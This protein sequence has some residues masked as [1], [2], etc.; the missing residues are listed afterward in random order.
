[1]MQ[2]DEALAAAFRAARAPKLEA[3]SRK[4][5]LLLLK[6]RSFDFLES[7]ILY[8]RDANLFL[9]AL[10]AVLHFAV[11]SAN[12]HFRSTGG[13]APTATTAL[14]KSD[15]VSAPRIYS[16]L[17][18]LKNRPVEMNEAL[19]A[20][21]A[22]AGGDKVL[23]AFLRAMFNTCKNCASDKHLIDCLVLVCEFLE[24]KKTSTS[25]SAIVEATLKDILSEFLTR[26][27]PSRTHRLI[28]LRLLS[29]SPSYAKVAQEVLLDRMDDVLLSS[30]AHMTTGN[31]ETTSTKGVFMQTTFLQVATAITTGLAKAQ[32]S[33][34]LVHAWI[35]KLL[36]GLVKHFYSS[37]TPCAW[38]KSQKL[39]QAV[40]TSVFE[41]IKADQSSLDDLTEQELNALLSFERTSVHKSVRP[42]HSRVLQLV[43]SMK[44]QNS[45]VDRVLCEMSSSK[46]R[47]KDQRKRERREKRRL[48]AEQQAARRRAADGGGAGDVENT[49]KQQKQRK[50]KNPAPVTAKR[51]KG[52]KGQSSKSQERPQA[53]RRKMEVD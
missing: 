27:R 26:T 11:V 6:L 10:H 49:Q 53:K 29:S 34:D 21:L 23:P 5:T 35:S 51:Q 7:F 41:C 1:M 14:P 16:C 32:S 45:R 31:A 4:E 50:D 15:L 22:S 8:S 40:F 38:T 13:Q 47:L 44:G 42:L 12:R 24:F 18:E 33:T 2:Q 48:R 20:S 52:K 28:L 17:K 3:K 9:P 43:H 39:S 19:A 30:E 46:Q 37:P 25:Q 36:K